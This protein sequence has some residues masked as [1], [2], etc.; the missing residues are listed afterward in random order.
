MVALVLIGVIA[1]AVTLIS[2][3]EYTATTTKTEFAESGEVRT[4]GWP[5]AWRTDARDGYFQCDGCSW[6]LEDGTC[7]LCF[8]ADVVAIFVIVFLPSLAL[9][10]VVHWLVR[11]FRPPSSA[12][13]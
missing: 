2:G 4:F 8:L 1:V 9:L 6:G 5:G 12:T 3:Y 7:E 11:R 13:R 10:T